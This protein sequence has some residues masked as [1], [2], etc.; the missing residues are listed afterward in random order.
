MTNERSKFIEACTLTNRIAAA[1]GQ[2]PLSMED[3]FG[4][5]EDMLALTARKRT[6]SE[7]KKAKRAS[8]RSDEQ[9]AGIV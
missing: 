1:A 2:Q 4:F 5:A 8:R 6:T 3:V 9:P 7:P